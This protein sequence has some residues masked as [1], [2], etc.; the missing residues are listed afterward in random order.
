MWLTFVLAVYLPWP[1]LLE[2]GTLVAPGRRKDSGPGVQR[3]GLGPASALIPRDVEYA[4]WP[5]RTLDLYGGGCSE[6]LLVK[7][8][9]KKTPSK[10]LENCTVTR[11]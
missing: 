2:G 6:A 8:G 10:L 3:A 1:A 9:E 11:C 5:F 4:I 7:K